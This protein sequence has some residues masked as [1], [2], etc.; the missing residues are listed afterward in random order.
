MSTPNTSPQISAGLLALAAGVAVM[1]VIGAITRLTESGL[2]IMEWAPVGGAL[3]PLSARRWQELFTL[4]Q[5]SGEYRQHPVSLETFKT[6]FWWE[7]IHRQWGRLL[8][9]LLLGVVAWFARA[10]L[11]RGGVARLLAFVFALAVL[12]AVGGWYLVASGFGERSDVAPWR[13]VFHLLLAL[14]IYALLLRGGL[15]A[16][17]RRDAAGKAPPRLLVACWRAGVV[18]LFLL[19]ASGGLVAGANAGFVYN[20]WPLMDGDFI[21]ADYARYEGWLRNISENPGAV[22]FHHRWLAA[23]VSLL[24]LVLAAAQWRLCGVCRSAMFVAVAVAVQFGLGLWTL[25]AVVP[26]WLGALHQAGALV[27]LTAMLWNLE[28]LRGRA[29]V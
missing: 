6:I 23:V 8:A 1:A 14:F 25:L 4:Y 20:T 11:L 26:V 2:S 12:Q 28:F 5:A 19:I 18:L 13:L 22:Q 3:P 27:L 24:V 10:R 16:M 21:P 9:L 7:W 29:I 17:P 15:R